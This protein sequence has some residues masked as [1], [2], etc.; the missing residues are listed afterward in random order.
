MPL[1]VTTPLIKVQPNGQEVESLSAGCF[2]ATGA[3]AV[4]FEQA[5]ARVALANRATRTTYFTIGRFMSGL[6]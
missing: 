5:T 4:E 1:Q 3:G 6:R 2:A